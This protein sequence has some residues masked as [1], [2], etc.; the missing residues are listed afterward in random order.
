MRI[1]KGSDYYIGCSLRYIATA[2]P[3]AQACHALP[4]PPAAACMP[5]FDDGPCAFSPPHPLC[6]PLFTAHCDTAAEA[7]TRGFHC[8]K[9]RSGF[10]PILRY[11]TIY[12]LLCQERA[13]GCRRHA[14]LNVRATRM[15]HARPR[16]RCAYH[17]RGRCPI[18][19]LSVCLR[20]LLGTGSPPSTPFYQNTM[21]TR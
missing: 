20:L 4:C 21:S 9:L 10:C 11:C 5:F 14:Q 17:P 16:S 7:S 8:R 2:R 13:E 19:H 12:S 6:L 1:Y 18:A 15:T 3:H